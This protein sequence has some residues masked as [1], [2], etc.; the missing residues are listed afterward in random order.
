[1]EW[2]N[3]QHRWGVRNGRRGGGNLGKTGANT[4]TGGNTRR[5]A[6]RV[7]W[8]NT[9]GTGRRT[10]QIPRGTPITGDVTN[11]RAFGRPAKGTRRTI[12]PGPGPWAGRA[13]RCVDA[14]TNELGR[15]HTGTTRGVQTSP[16]GRR[17]EKGKRNGITN[18]YAARRAGRTR[19][20]RRKTGW[21]IR[22][23]VQKELNVYKQNVNWGQR[24]AWTCAANW[25]ARELRG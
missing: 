22:R 8:G 24:R 14:R 23:Q 5:A 2:A 16:G 20:A 11:V 19:M 9:S 6:A 10:H 13:C 4:I 3:Q 21:A 1:M 17:G 12:Q 18:V 15:C 25:C 7:N